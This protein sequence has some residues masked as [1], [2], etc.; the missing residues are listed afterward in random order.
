MTDLL[1][2]GDSSAPLTK[3]PVVDG[4]GFYLGGDTPH[5]WSAGDFGSIPARIRYRLPIWTRSNP[6]PQIA[7]ADATSFIAQLSA[8]KAPGRTFVALDLESAETSAYVQTFGLL[9]NRAGYF[10]LVY[11][12]GSNVAS[13][14]RLN[15]IWLARP[16]AVTLVAGTVGTQYLENQTSGGGLYDLS[17]FTPAVPFWDTAPP[18]T[19]EELMGAS[20]A[21]AADGTVHIAAVGKENGRTTHLLH[22]TVTNGTPSVI[23][24]TAQVSAIAGSGAPFTV[25]P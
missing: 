10:I 17:W 23:D 9:L 22:V 25:A 20:I 18:F 3:Y 8:V 16:G 12:N 1:N 11:V 24:L 5:V 4:W 2:F 19:E 13:T 15:G 6:H 21:V 7:A 14:P